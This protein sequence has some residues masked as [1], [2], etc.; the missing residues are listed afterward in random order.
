MD[1]KKLGYLP[2]K[3]SQLDINSKFYISKKHFTK[4]NLQLLINREYNKTNIIEIEP[5]IL[6]KN[7]KIDKL[8]DNSL[9]LEIR[10]FSKVLERAGVEIIKI[11]PIYYDSNFITI[12]IETKEDK[13][14][15]YTVTKEYYEKN[16]FKYDELFDLK[17]IPKN[18]YIPFQIHRME[19]YIERIY[20]PIEKLLKM[21]EYKKL[22][23]KDINIKITNINKIFESFELIDCD[24]IK[25]LLQYELTKN[26]YYN[27][28]FLINSINYK[29]NIDELIKLYPNIKI[30]GISYNTELL[31]YCYIDFYDTN[32]LI[33]IINDDSEN[34]ILECYMKLVI[35]GK[36]KIDLINVNNNKIYSIII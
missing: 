1:G 2:F 26:E 29:I 33:E 35:S 24:I 30:G 15:Y 22:K 17:L 3:D 8:L 19:I 4:D 12:M 11:S 25:C 13:N 14:Y 21:K 23:S 28:K 9:L 34:K 18:I 16:I 20:K 32:T 5:Y 31:A 7:N 10:K 27:P 6:R 36:E